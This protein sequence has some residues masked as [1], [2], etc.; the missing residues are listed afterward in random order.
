MSEER[1][2]DGGFKTV[3][4]YESDLNVRHSDDGS[5]ENLVAAYHQKLDS[6]EFIND[7]FVNRFEPVL[8][9]LIH[10]EEELSRFLSGIGIEDSNGMVLYHIRQILNNEQLGPDE[11]FEQD[12]SELSKVFD[13][14]VQ[15]LVA[16]FNKSND[17][18]AID[19]EDMSKVARG[20]LM[21]MLA[22]FC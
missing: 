14:K 19:E 22:G 5:C 16:I 11:D 12:V 10:S 3:D 1:K 21:L 18:T 13:A 8:S 15:E 2:D 17:E 6:S 9:N 20:Y 4:L 7:E